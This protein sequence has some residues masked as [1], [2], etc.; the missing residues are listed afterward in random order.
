MIVYYS[1]L[2]WL[3]FLGEIKYITK[4]TRRNDRAIMLMGAVVMLVFAALRSKEIGADTIQY[5][6]HFIEIARTKF[7]HL[8]TYSHVWYGDIESGYKLYNKVLSLF[9]N[10]PQIITIANSILTVGLIALVISRESK[11]KWLSIF[12][13]F[14]LCFYQTALNLTPSSFT[15][16]FMFLSFPFIKKRKFVPFLIWVLIGISF[17]TSAI[18]FLPLYFLY[19][20]KI[21]KKTV[22]LSLTAGSV[23]VIFFPVILPFIL[24]FIPEAYAGY[25][26]E[27]VLSMR[28]D[29]Q[30]FVYA[31]QFL[32]VFLCLILMGRVQR[33]AFAEK[34]GVMC[35]TFLYETILYIFGVRFISFSR[36][37]FLFSPYTIIMIPE[38]IDYIGNANKR[39]IATIGI[40]VFGLAMYIARVCVNNVGYTMPYE[41]CF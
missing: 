38:L 3:V 23:G 22:A 34:N 18:F 1:I 14:T 8:S 20:I 10:N 7:S 29:G 5:Y 36:G 35:W 25:L 37:A 15:S 13:Y 16:Y 41:F 40:V 31:V 6:N 28:K 27:S 4:K 9:S 39:K 19:K 30:V 21:N 12:L 33:K 2:V 32:C 11:D 17:H 24:A 26:S